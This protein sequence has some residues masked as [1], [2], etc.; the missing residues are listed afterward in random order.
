[1]EG[2]TIS[3]LLVVAVFLVL[4]LSPRSDPAGVRARVHLPAWQAAPGPQRPGR[5]LSSGRL[6]ASS[7]SAFARRST[8]C[9]RR[10]SS[11]VT[12]CP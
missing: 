6:I 7:V 3:P 8:P 9:R 1:M 11:R 12:T 5:G 4:Y 2:V 10:T